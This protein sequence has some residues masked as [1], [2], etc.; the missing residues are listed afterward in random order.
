M[1]LIT[2]PECGGQI[3]STVNNCV[4]CGAKIK[5]CPECNCVY[6]AGVTE[7]KECGYK[8]V[9][10][11]IKQETKTK[12]QELDMEEIV[13][14][15]IKNF[16][17][18]PPLILT[19]IITYFVFQMA[20]IIILFIPFFKALAFDISS[21]SLLNLLKT[22]D[23]LDNYIVAGGVLLSFGTNFKVI[24]EVLSEKKGYMWLKSQ[25]PSL[26]ITLKQY[27]LKDFTKTNKSTKEKMKF[28]KILDVY[29]AFDNH[30]AKRIIFSLIKIIFSVVLASFVLIEYKNITNQLFLNKI[31]SVKEF[32]MIKCINM[33][34]LF[35]IIGVFIL[36]IVVN[37]CYYILT[38]NDV[39]LWVYTNMPE[40]YEKYIT[41][42]K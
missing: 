19:L 26:D 36:R 15:G 16:K 13:E 25:T 33:P 29:V 37:A 27:L 28:N 8:F 23:K 18:T 9:E 39:K 40:K 17:S 35:A 3:S 5:V 7:C 34:I 12:N 31:M 10:E 21:D 41:Y 2:C 30:I 1:A 6:I 42:L 22:Y 14:Q 24:S 32:D 4:H 20:G 38:S 11:I